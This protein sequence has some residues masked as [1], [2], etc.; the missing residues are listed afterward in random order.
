MCVCVCGMVHLLPRTPYVVTGSGSAASW[1][2]RR[3]RGAHAHRK[4]WPTPWAIFGGMIAG[5]PGRT[6]AA[7]IP[8]FPGPNK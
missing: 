8:A 2:G 5:I 7:P 6:W 3:L 4:V 1:H